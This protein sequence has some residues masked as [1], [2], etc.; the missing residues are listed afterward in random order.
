MEPLT[1]PSGRTVIEITE[2]RYWDAVVSTYPRTDFLQSWAWGELKARQG[3]KAQRLLLCEKDRPVAAAS[4]IFRRLPG[5][6]SISY[7]PR[8]PLVDWTNSNQVRD[9]FVAIEHIC[10]H[11]KAIFLKIDPAVES[12]APEVEKLLIRLG[13]RPRFTS[14]G[15]G[16]TQPKC[17]MRLD[18]TPP[19]EELL[20]ACKEKTRYNIRLAERKGVTVTRNT[21]Q[22]DLMVFYSLLEETAR[23]D[24]FVIRDYSY[25][26]DI[27]DL[28]ILPGQA[29]LF[30]AR[31]AGKTI[32]GALC[33]IFG[34]SC[35]Y[36]YGASSS[37][38][39][40]VMPNYALQ[41]SIIRWARE[42]GC[43]TYDL[44][45]VSQ[46]NYEDPHD[47][48]YGLNRFKAG[49]SPRFVEWIGEYDRPFSFLYPLWVSIFPWFQ[50]WLKRR[51]R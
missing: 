14:E 9:F 2:A 5:W 6:G 49:F 23:R 38:H 51:R 21:Q 44:R 11:Q 47:P 13:F 15:F 41:W 33:F 36:V 16:G 24:G 22:E 29:Q 48:L 50:A 7:I 26:R 17:V 39:R 1:L 19:L 27:W 43:R 30:L 12:P 32:A 10:R 28:F 31:Y 8:G 35:W 40:N 42:Q 20:A 37:E 46:R 18:L 4:I 25:Y 3:W 45:G 34:D